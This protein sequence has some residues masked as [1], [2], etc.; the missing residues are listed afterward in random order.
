MTEWIVRATHNF[1]FAVGRRS[2]PRLSR[3]FANSRPISTFKSN[4]HSEDSY[5]G[6][7]DFFVFF[8]GKVLKVSNN[9]RCAFIHI[10]AIMNAFRY[11]CLF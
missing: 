5:L 8:S 7:A 10:D 6:F 9:Y 11:T 2:N 3:V 1:L 4:D